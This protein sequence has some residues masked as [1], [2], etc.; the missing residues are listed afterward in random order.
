MP[1]KILVEDG[2][3]N[4]VPCGEEATRSLPAPWD[5]DWYGNIPNLACCDQHEPMR[6]S[7]A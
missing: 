6:K 4:Q 3:G 2:H 7:A 1:C 5:A